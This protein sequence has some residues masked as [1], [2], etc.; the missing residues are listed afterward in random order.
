M[1]NSGMSL[2]LMNLQVQP[3]HHFLSYMILPHLFQTSEDT[4]D[5]SLWANIFLSDIIHLIWKE[6]P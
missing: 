3:M 1:K 4:H 2:S 5:I 6:Y